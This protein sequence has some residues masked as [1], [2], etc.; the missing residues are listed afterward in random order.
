MIKKFICFFY[1]ACIGLNTFSQNEKDYKCQIIA[2]FM[3]SMRLNF[4][5]NNRFT[6]DLSCLK[7]NVLDKEEVNAD[8]CHFILEI[9]EIK[10][11]R[12]TAKLVAKN[13]SSSLRSTVYVCAYFRKKN[14]IWRIKS[15]Y[16]DF[17]K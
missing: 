17:V 5:L 10:I 11:K 8:S 7:F 9:H 12:K 13:F 2:E 14:E 15:T 3:D 1:W 4:L 6:Q 16:M